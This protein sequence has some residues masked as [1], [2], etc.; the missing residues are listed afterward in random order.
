MSIRATM[1]LLA[2]ALAASLAKAQKTKDFS[3]A[4]CAY[5]LPGP[6]WAWDDPKFLPDHPQKTIIVVKHP[7]RMVFTVT[8]ANLFLTEG[9]SPTRF[10]DYESQF[11]KAGYTILKSVNKP[12]QGVPGH[13]FEMLTQ[14]GWHSSQHV[15]FANGKMYVLQLLDFRARIPADFD[16]KPV[17]EGFRFTNVPVPVD[18]IRPEDIPKVDLPRPPRAE[19]LIIA[20]IGIILVATI[21][22][23][24]VYFLLRSRR[25]IR[26]DDDE[27]SY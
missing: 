22:L 4:F 12:L 19:P 14:E 27:D 10:E 24:V 8:Y 21:V 11:A 20:G 6:D 13:Y 18:V 7:S 25:P 17:F 2:L 26:Y 9:T 15:M 16:S 5:T 23:F 3:E 1:C